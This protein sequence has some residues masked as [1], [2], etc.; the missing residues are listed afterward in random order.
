M[1]SHGAVSHTLATVAVFQV[2]CCAIREQNGQVLIVLFT[3]KQ[4]RKLTVSHL[5]KVSECFIG[6]GF[7]R[8]IQSDDVRILWKIRNSSVP[9]LMKEMK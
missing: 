5:K 3:W 6:L 2:S 8:R 9:S 1:R 7:I 4:K